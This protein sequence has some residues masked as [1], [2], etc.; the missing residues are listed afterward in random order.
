MGAPTAGGKP[1]SKSTAS[2]SPGRHPSTRG[3]ISPWE[4][5]ADGKGRPWTGWTSRS[6]L[7]SC[8]EGAKTWAARA[9]VASNGIDI[10]QNTPRYDLI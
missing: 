6:T 1:S 3:P 9:H 2:S 4:R 5:A 8:P 7:F 10:R